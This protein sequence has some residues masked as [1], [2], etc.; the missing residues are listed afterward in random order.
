M[1]LFINYQLTVIIIAM[2][3]KMMMT[4]SRK[5]KELRNAIDMTQ[6]DL[7]DEL[8]ITGR[9]IIV[10][11]YGGYA[12]HG[13]GAF[14]GKDPTKVDRS[15]AYMARY[16]AKN[17]VKAGLANLKKISGNKS[18]IMKRAKNPAD[19]RK[20]HPFLNRKLINLSNS[21]GLKQRQGLMGE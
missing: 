5:I 1:C 14:S 19:V 12:R 8:G 4:L 7:A 15:A 16:I 21:I 9:K 13:G 10:D 2:E 18:T 6:N 3:G 11:T 20:E 17:A